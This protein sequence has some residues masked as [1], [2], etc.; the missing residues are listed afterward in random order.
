MSEEK[1][2]SKSKEGQ[3]AFRM[4]EELAKELKLASQTIGRPRSVVMRKLARKFVDGETPPRWFPRKV[5]R[6]NEDGN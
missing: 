6:R 3:F 1:R 2:K 5:K 4:E